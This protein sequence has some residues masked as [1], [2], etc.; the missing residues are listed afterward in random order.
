MVLSAVARLLVLRAP[1]VIGLVGANGHGTEIPD[2]QIRGLQ[3]VLSQATHCEFYP[4]LREGLRVRVRGGCLDGVEGILVERSP[5]RSLV[6]SVDAI[7]RSMI[8][9]ITGYDVEPI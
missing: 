6:L 3:T 5:G 8:I 4:F 7:C 9:R 1:G 2:Q